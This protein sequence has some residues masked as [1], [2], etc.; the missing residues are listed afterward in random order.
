MP[1]L[2][3][4]LSTLLDV[5]RSDVRLLLAQGRVEV[6][7][8]TAT[9]IGQVITRFSDVRCD[10]RTTQA[11]TARYLMLNKPS[12]VVCATVDDQHS[13]QCDHQEQVDRQRA[14]AQGGQPIAQKVRVL[15][16]LHVRNLTAASSV[17]ANADARAPPRY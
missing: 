9:D 12:G 8:I 3:R 14:A 10:G 13:E 11:N 4:H 15:R 5:K 6:D 7:G 1:R 2:D 17:G 16:S